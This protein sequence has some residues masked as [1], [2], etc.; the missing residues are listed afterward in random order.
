MIKK[1]LF[2]LCI[3]MVVIV[4]IASQ[5][6]AAFVQAPDELIVMIPDAEAGRNDQTFSDAF[7][8]IPGVS[9]VDYCNSQHCFY[10]LIDRTQQ[11][12]NKNIMTTLVGLGH[13][14]EIK[15]SGT[16]QEA[17]NNCADR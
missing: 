6:N 1:L 9:V 5:S 2:P 8:A 14:F 10:L 15:I 16:I 13:P 7:A 3:L 12:D 17:Q 11:P 4:G